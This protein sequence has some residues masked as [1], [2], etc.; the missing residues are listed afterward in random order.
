MELITI[1]HSTHSEEG[2]LKLLQDSEI[3]RLVDA[4]AFPGSPH[5][6]QNQMQVWLNEGIST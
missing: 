3:Q 1:G 6:S 4:R 2:F 5:F